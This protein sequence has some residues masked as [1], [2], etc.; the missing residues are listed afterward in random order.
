MSKDSTTRRRADLPI[1]TRRPSS[2]TSREMACARATGSFWDDATVLAVANDLPVGAD[3]GDHDRQ[4]RGHG[5]QQADGL[6][7]V[8]GRK[9]EYLRQAELV[10]HLVVR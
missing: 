5:L 9:D 1:R 10:A 7:L 2:S 8:M 4:T 6:A 3:I